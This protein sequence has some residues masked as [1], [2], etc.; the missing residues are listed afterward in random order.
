MGIGPAEGW[1]HRLITPAL[2]SLFHGLGQGPSPQS[3]AALAQDPRGLHL[4]PPH[5]SPAF[6]SPPA[7]APTKGFAPLPAAQ[8]QRPLGAPGPKGLPPQGLGLPLVWRDLPRGPAR[9]LL[10][11]P[12]TP[13]PAFSSTALTTARHHKGTLAQLSNKPDTRE[14]HHVI[15]LTRHPQRSLERGRKEKLG[16][17]S[18]TRGQTEWTAVKRDRGLAGDAGKFWR[19]RW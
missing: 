18:R 8:S 13:R 12:P 15:P 4:M 2:P 16:G 7:G 1:G 19:C 17:S 3:S 9:R 10:L 6:S 11:S 14:E 5:P